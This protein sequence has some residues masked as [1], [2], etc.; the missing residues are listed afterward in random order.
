MY[1]KIARSASER[2]EF[3]SINEFLLEETVP[4]FHH[5]CDEYDDSLLAKMA[6]NGVGDQ[7]VYLKWIASQTLSFREWCFRH[8]TLD[9]S[10]HSRIDEQD[11]ARWH[12][13][14]QRWTNICSDSHTRRAEH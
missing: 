3:G 8:T 2:L 4:R 12:H 9:E 10:Q 6:P 7:V 14:P 5:I 11:K 13:S 1:S